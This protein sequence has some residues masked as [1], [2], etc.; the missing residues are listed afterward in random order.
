MK[1][2][3]GP[4]WNQTESIRAKY[5]TQV[6]GAPLAVQ[7]ELDAQ[8][9]TFIGGQHLRYTGQLQMYNSRKGFGWVTMDDGYLLEEP[10]PKELKVEEP[11]V[12]A[13][14]RRPRGW[15]ENINVEFGIWKTLRGQYKVYN[16]TLPGGLPL[17]QENL[18]HRQVPPQG[19]PFIGAL[20][21]FLWKSGWGFLVVENQ[22]ALPDWARAKM[23]EMQN[24]ARAGGETLMPESD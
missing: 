10:V 6:G 16:M 24:S 12:N 2:R 15:I 5:V 4:K 14:G 1:W 17:L 18:E 7:D 23:A 13:G 8:K 22:A 19:Q 20:H 3:D 9:K 11:E 21:R